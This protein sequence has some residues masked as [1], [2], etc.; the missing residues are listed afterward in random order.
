M[1]EACFDREQAA[2]HHGLSC[3]LTSLRIQ[4]DCGF[5]DTQGSRRIKEVVLG[6]TG[7]IQLRFRRKTEKNRII[8]RG[9]VNS[10]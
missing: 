3:C 1:S 8:D 4:L 10:R 2:P 9:L 6:Y 7:L 5:G